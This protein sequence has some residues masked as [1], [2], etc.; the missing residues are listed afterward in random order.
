MNELKNSNLAEHLARCDVLRCWHRHNLL[1]YLMNNH[2]RAARLCGFIFT[3]LHR[4][5]SLARSLDRKLISASVPRTFVLSQQC[6]AYLSLYRTPSIIA[7]LLLTVSIT[8]I[9]VPILQTLHLW[10]CPRTITTLL[11]FRCVCL[12]LICVMLD[13]LRVINYRIII[14]RAVERLIFFNRVIDGVNFLTHN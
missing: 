3:W 10:H 6:I 2:I 11:C 5:L 1:T 14:N 9:T 12:I 4:A 13:Y 7:R 8:S